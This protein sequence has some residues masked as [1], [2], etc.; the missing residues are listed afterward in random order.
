MKCPEVSKEVFTVQI[1]SCALVL[2]RRYACLALII[3]LALLGVLFVRN[4]AVGHH[5]MLE[6]PR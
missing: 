2:S 1:G 5:M 4:A 3:I 6:F